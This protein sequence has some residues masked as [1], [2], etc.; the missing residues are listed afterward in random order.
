MREVSFVYPNYSIRRSSKLQTVQHR[1]QLIKVQRRQREQ[2]KCGFKNVN[3]EEQSGESK[4]LIGFS[5]RLREAVCRRTLFK[6]KS[7]G[8][9]H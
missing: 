1:Q 7:G 9:P 2:S 6:G 8:K 5:S 4:K 3:T